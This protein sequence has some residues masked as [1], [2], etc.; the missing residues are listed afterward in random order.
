M[1]LILQNNSKYL[2]LI[3]HH[4]KT[5]SELIYTIENSQNW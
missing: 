4:F 5:Q 3:D 1:T 2:F